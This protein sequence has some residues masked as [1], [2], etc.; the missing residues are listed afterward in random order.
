MGS[1]CRRAYRSRKCGEA[2]SRRSRCWAGV[3]GGVPRPCAAQIPAATLN[4][5]NDA[6]QAGEAD[7]ALS[8][9]DAAAHRRAWRA[10]AQNLI[11]RVRFSCNSGTRRRRRANRRCGSTEQLGRSHVAGPRSGRKGQPGLVPFGV[12]AG[13]AGA[14]EFEAG[15][16]ARSAKCPRALPTWAI[17]TKKRRASRAAEQTKRSDG[18]A[19][20]QD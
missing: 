3:P 6:L 1:P 12:L 10:E 8:A 4:Q 2:R 18:G 14:R 17:F 16:A 19:T 9:A 11:C 7:K 15:G 20:R 13:Q 5:A